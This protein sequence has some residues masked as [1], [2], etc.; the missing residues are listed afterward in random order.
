LW[1]S[2]HVFIKLSFNFGVHC[3]ENIVLEM[4]EESTC[5]ATSSELQI[6]TKSAHD[7]HQI[8]SSEDFYESMVT[9]SN[10][11]PR[12]LSFQ[13]IMDLISTPPPNVKST[14]SQTDEQIVERNGDQRRT[15]INNVTCFIRKILS[16]QNAKV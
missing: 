9:E 3:S 12:C 14:E 11:T 15:S 1:H 7:L 2:L 8:L 4:T 10:E 13:E 5:F 16:F 6:S